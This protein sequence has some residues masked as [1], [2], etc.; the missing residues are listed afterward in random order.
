MGWFNLKYEEYY[1][2][3]CANLINYSEKEQFNGLCED[4]YYDNLQGDNYED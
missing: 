2:N 4:C 1:C 3:Q